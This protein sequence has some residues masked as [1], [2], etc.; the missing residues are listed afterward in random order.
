MMKP[1]KLPDWNEYVNEVSKSI[2]RATRDLAK[3]KKYKDEFQYLSPFRRKEFFR[4]IRQ[5]RE[6]IEFFDGECSKIDLPKDV[7]REPL[8]LVE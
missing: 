3:L 5:L 8:Q 1:K 4:G 2:G 7:T 6:V